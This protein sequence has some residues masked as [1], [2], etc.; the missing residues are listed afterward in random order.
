METITQTNRT[1]LF[2]E[3]NPE[4]LNLITLIGDVRGKTSLDDDKIKEINEELLVSSFD[5][6]LDKFAPVV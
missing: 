6:F 1:M 5:E 4:R 3:I 2:A